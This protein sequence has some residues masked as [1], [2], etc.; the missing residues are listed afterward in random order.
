MDDGDPISC[1][2]NKLSDKSDED[3][4][5][6]PNKALLSTTK[7]HSF[8]IKIIAD[9]VVFYVK[10]RCFQSHILFINYLTFKRL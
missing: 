8:F 2:S 7:T 10:P 5:E 3:I 6:P 9:T 4:P 1:C